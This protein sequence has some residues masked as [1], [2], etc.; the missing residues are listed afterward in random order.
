[1]LFAVGMFL[2][3]SCHKEEEHNNK[4]CHCTKYDADHSPMEQVT[5]NPSNYGYN[6]CS[7][8]ARYLENSSDYYY[9]TCN[10]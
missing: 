6:S 5:Y 1:M 3:V 9:Y 2:A 10:G 7:E 8:L 4:T